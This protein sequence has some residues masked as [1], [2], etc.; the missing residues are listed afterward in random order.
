MVFDPLVAASESTV[1][2]DVGDDLADI[3]GELR[4][5]LQAYDAGATIHAVNHW[6]ESYCDHWGH[7][8]VG[9]VTAIDAYTRRNLG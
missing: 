1:V 2:G 4:H 8:A 6:R 3:Y 9:V 7:H 5:G